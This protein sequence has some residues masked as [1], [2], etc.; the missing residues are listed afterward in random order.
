[1]TT[2][3]EHIQ[4]TDEAICRNIDS[5]P[6]QRALLSQNLIAQLR[7]LVEGVAVR[8]H[9]GTDDAEYNYAAIDP[10]LNFVKAK[11]KLNFLGKFHKL[12]QISASHYTLDG[13]ASERLM[14][15]YYE[16]LL[17]IRTLLWDS[18]GVAVLANLESFPVDLDPSLREYH[19]KIA[20]RIEALRS[21]GSGSGARHRYYIHKTRPFF[22]G[23]R[24]YYEVTFYR[25]VNQ[26]SKF[27]RVIAFTDIDMTDK[28]SA[29]LTLQRDS[30]D[31][32]DQSMPIT[33]IGEWEV[34]IR[35]CEFNNF[36]RLL[37]ITTKVRTNSS[38][39]NYL[40]RGLTVGSGSLLDLIDMPDDKYTA[41]KAEGTV[42]VT[43]AQIFPVLDE[44]RRIVRSTA[45]GH[46]VI[47]Y[48]MLRMHNQVLRPQHHLEN[49]GRLSGLNL[50]Y[51]CIPFDQMPFCTSLP[52]HNPRYWDLVE[53]LDMT[54]RNH[55]LLAR[56]VRNNVD[57]HGML[58]TSAADLEEFGDVD[59]LIATY[60]GLLY[61]KHT[62]R[63]L[64]QDKGQVFIRGYEDD[65]VAI[66]KKLQ[67][68]ASSGIDGYTVT[69]ERWLDEAP[70]GIDDEAKR[71]ALKRLFSQ[72][73]VALVYG[74]AGTGK[75]TMVDH[76]ANYFN[77]KAKLF[78]A[79]TNPAIDNLKRR[80]TA[81]GSTFRT[82]SSQTY[83]PT[84]DLE[85]DLLVIDECSIVSNADLL[86]VLENTSF[87]LLVL[88]GD[89]Y[90]IQSIQFGNWFSIIRSFIPSTSVFELTTPFRT[91]SESLL[92]FWGK[93]RNLE[94]DIAEAIARNGYSTVLDKSLFEAQRQ[95]EII[96]CLNYDGLYGI[97]NVNRFLQSG[98]PNPATTW[99]VSTYKVDDPVLFHETER[100]R[101]V[102]YNNL[103]GR[104]VDIAAAPGHIRFDVELDRPLTEIDVG[105]GELERVGGSTVRFSVYDHDISDE[106][107]DS[108]NTSVPFQVAYA[109]SIHKAQGLEYD[110]VK[111][112]ITDANEDDITHSIFYTAVTRA[113]ES[114]KIFWTPETQ[115]SVLKSLQRGT[116]RKDVALLSS[117]RALRHHLNR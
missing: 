22:V 116:S 90:Q 36:A 108:V 105:G 23:G 55:E 95:D 79:H 40:M 65:T 46:N 104:I 33:I 18:F 9:A 97:N 39:Y 85:Y 7:N 101:P 32:L 64:V 117:R 89:V 16:Y 45:P 82:I 50:V 76:I 52:G 92:G 91:T 13:D 68:Y 6:D 73:K 113:R 60:N 51:G 37:G 99:R 66:V 87:K 29:I 28:Y 1:M 81:Q 71:D 62:G 42:G 11:A 44:A 114:L 21:A 94:D 70:R 57:R 115:Q 24:I 111:I 2:V 78:L 72:S 5:L 63:R 12:I 14:L 26:V 15:K 102:I 59:K 47:R 19:E 106:D 35:P 61:Y 3:V 83:Q 84:L 103:K 17:R 67:E 109:V 20:A 80:V 25:A 100:F 56:R 41:T 74:A 98:N 31:V 49:C 107:D 88:V 69:V 43:K 93:V 58:Y 30:I 54:G 10:G 4:S 48:L 110:S 77:D 53:A 34:S 86:K 96:L 112:V 27:D 75:S 8:L 38:E